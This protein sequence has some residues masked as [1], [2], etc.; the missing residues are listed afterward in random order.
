MTLHDYVEP[1]VPDLARSH[2]A[3]ADVPISDSEAAVLACVIKEALDVKIGRRPQQQSPFD[4]ST[5]DSSDLEDD[6]RFLVDVA[7]AYGSASTLNFKP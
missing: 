7:H 5:L 1:E 2:V 4:A 3:V 6:K